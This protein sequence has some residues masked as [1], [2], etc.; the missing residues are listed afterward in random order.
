MTSE[1]LFSKFLFV[2]SFLMLVAIGSPE[3]S[4]IMDGYCCSTKVGVKIT[5]G[6]PPCKHTWAIGVLGNCLEA[7]DLI[8]HGHFAK[9]LSE[10]SSLL[11]AP[12]T[13]VTEFLAVLGDSW[14]GSQRSWELWEFRDCSRK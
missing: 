3:L 1:N 13:A 6:F 8:F 5:A 7:L 14:V 12:L 11:P 4:G 10:A 2:G 9:T